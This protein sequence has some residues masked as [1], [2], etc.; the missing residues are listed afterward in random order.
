MGLNEA[1]QLL[2]RYTRGE[3]TPQERVIIEKW[4]EKNNSSINQWQSLSERSQKIWLD[5]VFDEILQDTKQKKY[6]EEKPRD[7]RRFSW[8]Y[9]A[10]A[11][12]ALVLGILAFW[13]NQIPTIRTAEP[14]LSISTAPGHRKQF[15]LSDG[16]QVWLQGG[17][18]LSYPK[19]FKGKERLVE[20]SG[21]AYFEVSKDSNH[22]FI[23][24]TPHL[25]TKVLGTSFNIS[26]YPESD[27]TGVILQEG[28]VNV[29]LIGKEDDG[30]LLA[31]QEAVWYQKTTD[32]LTKVAT[33]TTLTAQNL[34]E[35]NLI[36]NQTP[37]HEVL[38]RISKA[39]GVHFSYDKNITANCRLT[40]SFSSSQP[41][42]ELLKSI[43]ISI[44]ATYK[45]TGKEVRF[46]SNGC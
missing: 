29:Y 16:T 2:Y 1:E 30:I 46:Q 34:K 11:A 38:Y 23:V 8:L 22:S 5:Q 9:V 26:A 19:Q 41:I 31:P 13:K 21:E 28:A 24:S 4:L 15:M 44:S 6:N 42:D 3:C 45:R 25:L 37:L 32:K 43:S 18:T 12:V 36:F 7:L 35:G 27:E 17:S 14:M 39:Y 20:L 33:G 40:G 10:A